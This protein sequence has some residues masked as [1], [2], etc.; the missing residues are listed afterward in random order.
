MG[1]SWVLADS[2]VAE[3]RDLIDERLED[4]FIRLLPACKGFKSEARFDVDERL[5]NARSRAATHRVAGC[6]PYDRQEFN[7]KSLGSGKEGYKIE[8]IGICGSILVL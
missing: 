8:L 7:L 1:N 3:D 5:S 2:R 4:L 6:V